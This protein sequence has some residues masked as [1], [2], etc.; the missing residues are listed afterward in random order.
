MVVVPV[1]KP[2][3]RIQFPED[4]LDEFKEAVSGSNLTKAGLIEVLK[5]RYALFSTLL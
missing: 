3:P 5:K 4:K 1:S 2:K